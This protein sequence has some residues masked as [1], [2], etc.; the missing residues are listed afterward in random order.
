[1]NNVTRNR[2]EAWLLFAMVLGLVAVIY[3]LIASIHVTKSRIELLQKLATNK[4]KYEILVQLGR[5]Y[6]DSGQCAKAIACYRKALHLLHDK[7]NTSL[8]H[9]WEDLN[10][11][12]PF[13]SDLH[14]GFAEM[15][16]DYR[17]F[18]QAEME[19]RLAVKFS[20]GENRFKLNLDRVLEKRSRQS[21]EEIGRENEVLSAF[22]KSVTKDWNPPKH[23]DCFVT[24]CLVF[25]MAQGPIDVKVIGSS[26][27][28]LHDQSAVSFLQAAPIFRNVYLNGQ[29]IDCGCM[30]KDKEKQIASTGFGEFNMVETPL[31][32]QIAWRFGKWY[33]DIN[34][35]IG[36][37][38]L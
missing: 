8:L 23:H 15:F 29:I 26:G 12:Q 20:P 37:L 7:S 1:M 24:R 31:S 6:A 9:A 32:A 11:L 21:R 17:C 36:I 35:T 30:S 2:K 18:D 4:N 5:V 14:C 25:P 16:E 34:K 22:R 19:Y 10:S 33:H 27:S 38:D 13:N 3:P 28:L